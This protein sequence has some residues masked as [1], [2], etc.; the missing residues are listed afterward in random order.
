M[1]HLDIVDEDVSNLLKK[2]QKLLNKQQ[3]EFNIK[4]IDENEEV[5]F[6]EKGKRIINLWV[7]QSTQPVHVLSNK[8]IIGKK[9]MVNLENLTS[10]SFH[11]RIIN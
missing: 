3:E 4:F 8:N 7:G 6:T 1:K 9:L 5:L 2:I 10:F 11:G